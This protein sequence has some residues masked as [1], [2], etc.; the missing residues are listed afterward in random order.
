MRNRIIQCCIVL[1]MLATMLACAKEQPTYN[2]TEKTEKTALTLDIEGV[3]KLIEESNLNEFSDIKNK[4]VSI[5]N[6]TFVA[7]Y[8]SPYV[9]KKEGNACIA[10][11]D[12]FNNHNTYCCFKVVEADGTADEECFISYFNGDMSKEENVKEVSNI[13]IQELEDR[14]IV[15]YMKDNIQYISVII[16]SSIIRVHIEGDV[17]NATAKGWLANTMN[18]IYLKINGVSYTF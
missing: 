6:V 18:A 3:N 10:Y 14:T 15:S 12:L 2:P 1:F 17:N 11:S 13:D 8:E 5:G 9:I 4:Y 16:G 7:E